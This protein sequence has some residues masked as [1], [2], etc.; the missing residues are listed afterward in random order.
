MKGD[1]VK[2][3]RLIRI[4]RPVE[5][6]PL[7][8]PATADS[9]QPLEAKKKFALPLFGKK[10]T[11]NFRSSLPAKKP[12]L[13]EAKPQSGI[14]DG[15]EE[16]EDEEE[17]QETDTPSMMDVDKHR[18]PDSTESQGSSTQ[19]SET[20][21]PAKPEIP[22]K[23]EKI[24]DTPASAV[25]DDEAGSSTKRKRNN[26]NRNRNRN[27][28]HR[29]DYDESEELTDSTKYSGWVPPQDQQGDGMTDLNSKFG[30]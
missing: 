8:A 12:K 3:Q 7:L 13:N 22:E 2:L 23:R 18:K 25:I 14:I 24:I 27:K 17:K 15:P 20:K 21:S 19:K 29:M 30:Y 1:H 5:L 9:A 16:E 28:N 10:G 6:P 4:A 26:R 11:F